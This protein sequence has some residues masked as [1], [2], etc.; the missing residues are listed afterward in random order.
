MQTPRPGWAEQEPEDWFRG[1]VKS[2]ALALELLGQRRAEVKGIG[3]TGQMHSTVLLDAH[4]RVLRP[5]I[6]WCDQRTEP[7]CEALTERAGGL[8]GLIALTRNRAFPG[9]TAPKLLWVRAHEPDIWRRTR[10]ILVGKDYVRWRFTG[11]KATEVTDAS[12]TLL[13]DVARRAWSDR[14]LELLVLDR[15]LLPRCQES[16]EA[17]GTLMPDVARELELAPRV[18]VFAGAGDQAAGAVAAGIVGE[19]A[20]SISL[21]TSGVV[22]VAS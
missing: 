21:G 14:L 13:L 1:A 18:P 16:S 17:A 2:L 22:F 15:A 10:A 11:A 19:G 6:L 12:G 4:E 5:A 9:F 3:F 8:A 20:V 7:Q